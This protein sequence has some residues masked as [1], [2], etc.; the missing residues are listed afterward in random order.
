MLNFD[1]GFDLTTWKP[2]IYLALSH[3]PPKII[4]YSLIMGLGNW[5]HFLFLQVLMK[6]FSCWKTGLYILMTDI[7]VLTFQR[8][9]TFCF[10]AKIVFLKT[11]AFN[12]CA[13]RQCLFASSSKN[14]LWI[15]LLYPKLG[16]SFYH[17]C[18]SLK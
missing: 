4:S 16:V 9:A 1:S 13:N 7:S 5:F 2:F 8:V 18:W 10:H 14:I 11:E 3:W 6:C 12:S 17:T 15:Q